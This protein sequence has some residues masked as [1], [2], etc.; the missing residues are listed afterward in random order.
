MADLNGSLV[1][2]IQIAVDLANNVQA[3]IETQGYVSEETAVILKQFFEA[4]D[5]VNGMLDEESG[6]H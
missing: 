5:L 4:H 6:M 1:H 2:L 3:D